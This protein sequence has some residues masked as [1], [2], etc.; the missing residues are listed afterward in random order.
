MEST[1]SLKEWAKRHITEEPGEELFG[2]DEIMRYEQVH[3]AVAYHG[4]NS[5]NYQQRAR[6]KMAKK[7]KEHG[8]ID[9]VDG[10]NCQNRPEE[11]SEIFAATGLRPKARKSLD[12]ELSLDDFAK[13][14]M[15]HIDRIEFLRRIGDNP[16]NY[17]LIDI[18]ASHQG[19]PKE[20]YLHGA[21]LK[22]ACI[23]LKE[24]CAYVT[25]MDYTSHDPVKRTVSISAKG[26]R[27]KVRRT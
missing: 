24:R 6:L 8:C 21:E 14:R 26:L 3:L 10:D 16:D 2:K 11:G 27:K 9:V 19:N 17:D 15:S 20:D 12:E 22:L 13:L 1:Q 18:R 23:A 25:N 4:R 7:A 5:H